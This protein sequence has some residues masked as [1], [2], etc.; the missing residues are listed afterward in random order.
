MLKKKQKTGPINMCEI[1][2]TIVLKHFTTLKRH[3]E[4]L[5]QQK[6]TEGEDERRRKDKWRD[7]D[8]AH[9][10]I[11]LCVMQL[12]NQFIICFN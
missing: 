6:G 3:N 10:F 7:E 12:D 1:G 8:F 2:A 9:L 5:F 11:F 4:G